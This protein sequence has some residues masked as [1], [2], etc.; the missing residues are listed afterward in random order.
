MRAALQEVSMGILSALFPSKDEREL[1]KLKKTADK[2]I[3]LE[4]VFQ[5][6]TDEELAACTQKYKDRYAAGEKLDDLL[7]EA[8]ATVREAS[9]RVLGMKH[10][11]VQIIGG[12]VL[13]QGRIAEMKTGEGKTLVATLPAYLNALTGK[14]MHVVTVN[15]YL[16][17]YHCDWMG[18][19]FRFLGLTVGCNLHALNREQKREVY[20]CDIMYTTNS[21]LGF[22]YLRDNMVRNAKNRVQRELAFA[23]VDEVDSI[24][25]DEART[26]LIISGRG[27]TSA[28]PYKKADRLMKLLKPAEYVCPNCGEKASEEWVEK[29]GKTVICASCGTKCDHIG[30]YEFSEKDKTVYLNENGSEKAEEFYGID[31][32]SAYENQKTK[33]YIDNALRAHFTMKKEV[34]YIVVDNEV[35]I[36]DEFTGRQMIGRR[37][38]NGLHQAIEAK[39]GV[40]IKAEDKTLASITYQNF[41]RLYKKLSGMTGTAKTEENEFETI[42]RL[43]VVV[44]PTNKPMIRVDEP[45]RLYV[46]HA[47]KLKAIVEDIKACYAR[48][49]PV[50]VGTISVEKSEELSA[51]LKRE[52]INHVVLNAKY[53]AAEA[54]IVAQAGKLGAVTIATNMAGRGTDIMLGGNPDF[55][56]K[57]KLDSMGYPHDIVEQA[58][59]HA[60]TD[61]EEVLKAREEYKKYYDLF[62]ADTDKE[63]EEVVA[64]GGLRIIGT[65]RHESRR[66]D[67]QL[68]GRS[69]RQGD[70]GSSV[71]YIA[72]DDDLLRIFGGDLLRNM[73]LKLSGGDEDIVI[74]SKML[75]KQVEHAQ[76]R[77]E[78][79]N[80]SIRKHVISYDDVLN[81]QREIIY[82]QRRIVLD[83]LDV[84]EQIKAMIP[85]VIE[86]VCDPYLNSKADYS[87]WDYEA[88]NRDIESAVLPRGTELIT[89][90]FVE[91]HDDRDSFLNAVS[92][93]A[94]KVFEER[95]EKFKNEKI[96]VDVLERDILL[97]CVDN[98]WTEHISAMEELRQ[99]ISL[100]AYGHRDPVLVYRQEGFEMFDEMVEN[101]QSDVV[102]IIMKIQ[103]EAKVEQPKEQEM[104]TTEKHD[105]VTLLGAEKK[106]TAKPK[107]ETVHKEKQPRPNDPCPCGSGKKYKNCCGRTGNYYNGDK[108][109]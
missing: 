5:A 72:A 16:A 73:I 48:R 104:Q 75:S 8:F 58:T 36:V 3:A 47:A 79:R 33:H 102:K 95:N 28:E 78:D 27:E 74:E 44:I 21:E 43:D 19:V 84:H 89:P 98:R 29:C 90:D 46:S 25:V 6:M 60:H 41:F 10:F 26:P 106:K 59:S 11:Y 66:I 94:E 93:E 50:L 108:A 20:N 54:E 22:D 69:G 77:V 91:E 31:D 35:I 15:E 2:V 96:P 7:P 107:V 32:L 103:V 76:M 9:S 97:R 63:K 80:F 100:V 12:I 109:Q 13:H 86:R 82:E 34:N 23:I 17:K 14:G 45:D 83:E 68:R 67:N 51:L 61:N 56:A 55:L 99:G 87:Q 40:P 70:P 30:D 39:E 1:K 24:L 81:K 38:S 92:A 88:F 105:D 85:K 71:F 42:Y 101:I 53:H 57:K 49:Q 65:E 4:P 37:F 62:K 52:K 64:L 18:K